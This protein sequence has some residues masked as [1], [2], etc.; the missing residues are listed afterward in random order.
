MADA[1]GDSKATPSP[2]GDQKPTQPEWMG[3]SAE[4]DKKMEEGIA[5]LLSK[6]FPF[7][8][9]AAD[10]AGVSNDQDQIHPLPLGKLVDMKGNPMII[11]Q[12]YIFH[13]ADSARGSSYYRELDY[14]DNKKCVVFNPKWHDGLWLMF[15]K[16]FWDNQ[17]PVYSIRYPKGDNFWGKCWLQGNGGRNGD[18][19]LGAS[20]P[21]SVWLSSD[22]GVDKYGH[23]VYWMWS[24]IHNAEQV[25]DVWIPSTW[26]DLCA[27]DDD[28]ELRMYGPSGGW[29][30][31]LKVKFEF[32]PW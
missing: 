31:L 22:A 14:E 3:K 1:T 10:G 21:D 32:V 8:L 28:W 15:R 11:E 9:P 6:P 29:T 4:C 13:E 12:R 24:I 5:E 30:G 16:P 18:V 19:Q 23:K 20:M 17:G 26:V 27:F 7:K 25:G 2:L